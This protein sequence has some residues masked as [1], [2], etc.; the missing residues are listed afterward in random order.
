[1]ASRSTKHIRIKRRLTTH[2]IELSES[3]SS[4]TSSI[5]TSICTN[6]STSDV[7]NYSDFS[8]VFFDDT[9]VFIH[10]AS[11]L[12]ES[13]VL[14]A[15]SDT[16]VND[17]VTTQENEVSLPNSENNN[18]LEISENNETNNKR[19]DLE[20]KLEESLKLWAQ[21]FKVNHVQLTSL[22]KILN[23][24]HTSLLLDSRN[25]MKTSKS[26]YLVK[27]MQALKD[28]G[29]Y[30][31]LGIK[32]GIESFLKV[33]GIKVLASNHLKLAFNIDGV[34]IYKSSSLQLWPILGMIQIKNIKTR[35]FVVALFCG[36]S[37][38]LDA[39]NFCEEFI[40]EAQHLINNGIRFGNLHFSISITGVV[41]DA[42]ARSF[43]KK[44]KGHTGYN[45]C[46]RC[47]TKG[48]YINHKM[49][50]PNFGLLR[51]HESF[52]NQEDSNHHSG[53]SLFATLNSFDIIYN[54]PLDY[55][56][57]ACLG[58]MRRLLN[59]WIK[60]RQRILSST[61]LSLLN[62]S[63]TGYSK[64]IPREF[65]RKPRSVQEIDT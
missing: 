27:D 46:E 12:E 10:D 4:Q 45:G 25:I 1:M 6:S 59:T 38:P 41:C 9:N 29:Q 14:V 18:C 58:V 15:Y 54:F 42:P 8:F 35:P 23:A 5:D 24:Y 52:V 40:N 26:E 2:L 32:S 47:D 34:Q 60:G 17:E 39:N 53:F 44:I 55:M 61:I 63:I 56:H 51:T 13:A 57:L 19:D 64:V 36:R 28:I 20:P 62:Q 21:E 37:K 7:N 22:L 49:V 43:L 30:V 16:P 31:Y 48:K 3:S 50:F 33:G 65:Q 11:T